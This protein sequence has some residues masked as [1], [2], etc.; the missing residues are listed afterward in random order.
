MCCA[1]VLVCVHDPVPGVRPSLFVCAGPLGFVAPCPVALKAS[2]S[3]CALCCSSGGR[4][5]SMLGITDS[6]ACA[7][8]L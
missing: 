2:H 5:M 3:E 6:K 4:S 8:A 7:S 1:R